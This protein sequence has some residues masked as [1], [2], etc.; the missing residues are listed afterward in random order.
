[1]SHHRLTRGWHPRVSKAGMESGSAW[2]NPLK[3]QS[4]PTQQRWWWEAPSTRGG[5]RVGWAALHHLQV[6]L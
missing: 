6:Q 3:P 4:S 1:M 2:L 5:L